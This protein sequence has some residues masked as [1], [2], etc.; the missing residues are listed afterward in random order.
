[1]FYWSLTLINLDIVK[2]FIAILGSFIDPLILPFKSSIEYTVNYGDFTVNYTILIFGVMILCTV[3]MLTIIG[4]IL[5]F[6]EKI[7]DNLKIKI[8]N[9]EQLRKIE[10]DKQE[11][12]KE[13]NRNRT[14]YVI[15]KLTK[16]AQQE[17]YLIK[18]NSE[19]FFSVGLVD[20]YENSIANIYKKFS[21]KFYG[22]IDGSDNITG[23]I[24]TDTKKVVEFLTFLP[25]HI[26]EVNK[27]MLDLNTIFDYK[28]ACHSSYS[29]ASANVDFEITSKIL[30]L[31]GSKEILLSELIKSKLEI[32]ENNNF[33]LYSRG[34]YLIK[35]KQMDVY[36]LQFD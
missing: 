16:N 1:V 18:E 35:D 22:N 8:K 11:F 34:I 15:L 5:N 24:F 26:E 31:C 36:K 32:L 2:P 19:D 10:E 7:I 30:N 29:D 20:S 14:I 4:R 13:L 33:R 28:I 6:I 3:L 25:V 27:G 21:G 9:K 23:F 12:I 17:A